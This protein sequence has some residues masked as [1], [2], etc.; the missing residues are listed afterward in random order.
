MKSSGSKKIFLNRIQVGDKLIQED[1]AKTLEIIA[2]EGIKGFYEGKIAKKISE[3]SKKR[4]GYLTLDD[5]K[6]YQ[7][8]ERVPVEG[9]YRGHKIFSMGPPSSGGIHVIQ[10]LQM[11]ENFKFDQP[12]SK[13]TVHLVSSAMQ[14][15][16]VDRAKFLGDSDFVYVPLNL[17]L[18]NMP[19]S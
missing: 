1:L 9:S 13:K 16:F 11:L 5:F 3:E 14:R 19:N 7:T 10:I 6:S 18:K 12:Y 15:A 4:G 8:I 17:Y 2:Q